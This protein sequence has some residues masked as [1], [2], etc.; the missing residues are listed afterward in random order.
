MQRLPVSRL[1]G[2]F[3]DGALG[4]QAVWIAAPFALQQVIRLASNVLLAY[5]LAPQIFGLMLLVNTLR[6]GTE[7]LS[8]IGIGQSVV[9]SPHGEEERFLDTAWTVQLLRGLVLTAIAIAL[10]V[11]IGQIYDEPLLTPILLAI[12]PVFLLAG[13]QSPGLFLIQRRMSLRARAVYDLGS[14]A[15]QFVFT[16]SLAAMMPTVWALVWGLV[17]SNAF[18]TFMS[19]AVSGKRRPAFRLDRAAVIELVSFGKWIF[20]STMLYF[21]ATSADTLYF[22]AVLPLALAGVYAI[23]RTFADLFDNLAQRAGAMIIFPRMA[24]LGDARGEE[25]DRLR[26]KR[27]LLLA[28]LA[29]ALGLFLAISDRMILLLYDARYEAAAFM[30]PLLLAGVWFRV[31]SSFADAMLM[32]C[33]R[34][35]PGA[36]ANGTK[37]AILVIGLPLA[38]AHGGLFL[39]LLVLILAEAG[40]WL[41]LAPMLHRER[42]ASPLDDIGLTLLLVVATAGFKL[43]LSTIGLVPDFATWWALGAPLHG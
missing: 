28:G 22:V 8:D 19:Y 36:F 38:L 16:V 37:F 9:R 15:F 31:L 5:L 4:R 32:G 10:A 13:L 14:T 21:A 26:G 17:V 29:L 41:V 24:R 7:L 33:G 42:L 18:A 34:P 30:L 23:A 25:A 35:A 3:G 11:P 27:R 20:L 40:R 39:A 1:T 6:T 43:A 2:H 12:S